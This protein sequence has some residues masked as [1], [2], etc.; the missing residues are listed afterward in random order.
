MCKMFVNYFFKVIAFILAGL[1]KN[2]PYYPKSIPL[3]TKLLRASHKIGRFCH[4]NA[5]KILN[6]LGVRDFAGHWEWQLWE[7]V[8]FAG[9]SRV[10]GH[11]AAGDNCLI[12]LAA[13]R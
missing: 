13:S 5:R 11:L 6:L 1:L 7:K 12:L 4:P 10:L 2:S 3:V 8:N 9:A